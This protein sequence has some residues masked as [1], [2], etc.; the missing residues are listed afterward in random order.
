MSEGIR[1]VAANMLALWQRHEVLANNLANISTTGFKRDDVLLGPGG[2]AQWTDFAQGAIEAT[3]R[4]LDVAL[5]G[6]GFFVVEGR[7]GPRYTRAAA[8]GVSRQGDLVTPDGLRILGTR[9]PIAV[10]SGEVT[11]TA[12][13]E[14]REGA[15]ALDTLRVVDF[16][17]PYRLVKEG[18]GLFAPA[19]AGAEPQPV[20]EPQIASASLERSNVSVV[21]TIVGMIETL[22][23]YESAQKAIQAMD[24]AE[25]QAANEIGRV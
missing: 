25:R 3:G 6:D 18:S 16:P 10:G 21:E 20:R 13:G 4:N 7:G 8:L 12:G 17:R 15:R 9:G 11:V 5:N 2:Q 1:S 23:Y 14:V 19:G 22:R 24:E